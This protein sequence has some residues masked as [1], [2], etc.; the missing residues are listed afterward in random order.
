MEILE[1]WT[2]HTEQ[3]Q[4]LIYAQ[5]FFNFALTLISPLQGSWIH[6]HTHTGHLVKQW[7]PRVP[8]LQENTSSKGANGEHYYLEQRSLYMLATKHY[9]AE[10]PTEHE[11]NGKSFD[12]TSLPRVVQYLPLTVPSFTHAHTNTR[13]HTR[14]P[15]QLAVVLHT[16]LP[17]GATW[18]FPPTCLLAKAALSYVYRYQSRM[19]RPQQQMTNAWT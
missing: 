17:A 11:E 18:A 8:K 19:C 16:L 2:E 13:I 7:A 4:H 5:L 15:T 10:E 9:I 6:A 1:T 3:P 14:A 12:V